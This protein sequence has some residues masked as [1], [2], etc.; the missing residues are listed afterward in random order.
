[1]TSDL[2][3]AILCACIGAYALAEIALLLAKAAL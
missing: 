2:F 3:N 1:M